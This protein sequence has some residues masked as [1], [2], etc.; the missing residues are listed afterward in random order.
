VKIVLC[1]NKTKKMLIKK[2]AATLIGPLV[3]DDTLPLLLVAALVVGI[4]TQ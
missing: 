3:Q 2:N 1:I 4:V